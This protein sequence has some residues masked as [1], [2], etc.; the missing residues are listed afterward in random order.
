ME[1]LKTRRD[2]LAEKIRR[3]ADRIEKGI[4]TNKSRTVINNQKDLLDFFAQFEQLHVQVVAKDK[5]SVSDEAH[6]VMYNSTADL[7]DELQEKAEDFLA[8]EEAKNVAIEVTKK[9]EEMEAVGKEI[10]A[11][12]LSMEENLKW[13]KQAKDEDFKA[14]LCVVS[15]AIAQS[16]LKF[17][18]CKKLEEYIITN[19]VHKLG[20]I[21]LG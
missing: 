10:M 15:A 14:D 16:D 3:S 4:S 19:E 1:E 8:N 6:R 5:Q 13:I 9:Y 11:E 21:C 20:R 12:L 2:L 7:V 18:K 17:E